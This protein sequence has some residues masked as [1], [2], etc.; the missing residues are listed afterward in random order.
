MFSSYSDRTANAYKRISVE[1]SMNTIDQHKL[2]ALLFEGVLSSIAVA[3]GAMARGDVL[4]KVNAV[5]KA[6]RIL[7]EGLSTA[8]DRVDGGELAANLSD[9]YA[10][11][12]R[13]LTLA[14]VRNDDALMAEVSDLI[15]PIAKGWNEM[16]QLGSFQPSISVSM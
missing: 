16:R 5:T 6:I 10:Y 13:Q 12:V 11:C 14:N 2:A 1:T 3:R 7:E 9:L 15:Q 8:L 4:T